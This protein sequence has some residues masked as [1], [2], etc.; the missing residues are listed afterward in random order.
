[1]L[2]TI[3]LVIIIVYLLG[4][5]AIGLATRG[6]QEDTDD[7]FTAD[8]GMSGLFGSILVGLSVAATLFSGISFL[9]YPA[10]IY[11]GAFVVFVGTVLVA[12]PAAMLV[13]IWFLP[14]YFR[15]GGT[16]PYDILEKRFGRNVRTFS[17][18]MYTLMRIGWMAALI[19]AP[20]LAI[21][22]AWRLDDHWFWPC[23]LA[24]GL[25]STV[26]TVFGGIRG[27]IVTD[28]LQFVVIAIGIA[29]TIGY[30]VFHLPDSIP[31]TFALLRDSGR[32]TA[33]PVDLDPAA[34]FT[35]FTVCIG[36]TV[37][38]LGNYIGDQ[39]SLQRYLASGTIGPA[40][41]AFVVNF[42]GVVL[43]IVLLTGVGLALFA[44]Y[45]NNTDPTLPVA[46]DKIFPHFIA[47]QLPVGIAGLLLAAILAATM[48]SMT[49]GINALSASFTLDLLPN[50]GI[51]LSPMGQL[52][53]ARWS[54]L[55]IGLLSTVAAGFVG[56]LGSLYDVTQIMLGVFAAPLL[57]VVMLSVT[58]IRLTGPGVI[59]GM[60]GGWSVGVF[61]ALTSPIAVLW[62][63]PITALATLVLVLIAGKL[64]GPH[65]PDAAPAG[66]SQADS[67][68]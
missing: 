19:Y 35:I 47:T 13:L 34:Q 26:Y 36:V 33:F 49:S 63:A 50:T 42:L 40:I 24:I 8:G 38:N 16:Q 14:R 60:I 41:R 30:V 11:G 7:Y 12:M 66:P 18:A 57:V 15:A 43:V 27:V 62:T 9:A 56:K 28:A 21:M 55:V 29:A 59:V 2:S 17:S 58:R 4:T 23:I 5:I 68:A 37:A 31:D 22:A 44:F 3:D 65:L 51:E 67:A 64:V 52:V 1:M 32:L 61:C 54:S 45:H 6:K 48:S 46:A 25:S 53:F 39:M 10:I 20:T